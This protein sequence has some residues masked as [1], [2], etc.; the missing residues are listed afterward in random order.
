MKLYET[1]RLYLHPAAPYL[2]AEVAAYYARNKSFLQ[3]FE[4]EHPKAF[5]TEAYH[6]NELENDRIRAEQGL[7]LRLW[8]TLKAEDEVDE[9]FKEPVRSTFLPV[10]QKGEG[11]ALP[12]HGKVVGMVGLNNII[13]GSFCSCHL[14]YKIDE[15]Y[16]GRGLV[17]EG[18]QALCEVAFN[19]L[20]LHRIEAN[21]MPRNKASL[22][23]V[24]KLGFKNEGLSPK[25]LLINGV[26]EDHVH[27]VLLAPE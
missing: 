7:G 22:R 4:P 26:W 5:Y 8:M 25:Y 1:K 18:V 14:A 21:I 3:A 10:Y 2:A 16:R 24:E 15:E 11:A 19:G 13:Y 20:G 17:P 23:V 9:G 6:K 27:M 12:H